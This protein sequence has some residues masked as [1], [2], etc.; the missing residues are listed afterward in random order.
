MLYSEVSVNSG[1]SLQE[2][3]EIQ[4]CLCTI[5][6]MQLECVSHVRLKLPR[7]EDSKCL[8]SQVLLPAYDE[9]LVSLSRRNFN[10]LIPPELD[11]S[12]VAWKSSGM[13]C[14]NFSFQCFWEISNLCITCT[15]KA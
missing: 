15:W 6:Y 4:A 5:L 8:K 9:C 10:E 13:Y 1:N 14:V 7:F 11:S 3:I 12:N 2:P